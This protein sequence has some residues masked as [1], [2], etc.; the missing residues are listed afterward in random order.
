M[1][2]ADLM[3]YSLLSKKDKAIIT[4]KKGINI[5]KG[6]RF[7]LRNFLMP[8]FISVSFTIGSGT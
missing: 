4:G 3:R 7:L 6:K 8:I 2:Y 5:I 1:K